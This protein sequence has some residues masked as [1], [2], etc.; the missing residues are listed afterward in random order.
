MA[1]HLHILGICGTFMGGL[2]QLAAA[3]GFR[4]T[5]SDANVYPP[6]STQLEA[7]GIALLEGYAPGH[8]DPA[9]DLVIIGNALSRGNPAVETVLARGLDYCS[10]P[11][12]L[13]R[14]VLRGRW[15]LGVAGT[16]GKTTTSSLLAWILE[17]AGLAPGFLIGGVPGNF[18]VSARE[19]GGQYFVVEADEYDTA[20]FDKRSKFVHYRPKTL[21]LGNLEYDHADIFP[22]LAA[23]Q[24]QFHHLLRCVPGNGRILRPRDCPALDEVEALGCWTPVERWSLAGP[25]E[26]PAAAD[27]EGRLQSRDGARLTL[28]GPAG[29]AG[30]VE[31]LLPGQHN[32]NNAIAA[33]AAA[34]HAGVTPERALAALA[35]FRGVKRRLELLG[36]VAGVSVYDDF[37]H[38][39]TAIAATLDA[40]RARGCSGRLLAL[41]EPRS[42]TMR[43]GRHREALAA[44]VA[45]AD[46]VYWYQPP[47]MDW[48]LEA[49][50]A[51]GTVP[52]S[53]SDDVERLVTAVV[54]E[55][56]KGDQIVIMSNGSFAGIHQRLLG[57]L[58]TAVGA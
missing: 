40:L 51:A 44:S 8:L 41:V 26:A 23:I 55:A 17:D 21:V 57:A 7:A 29:D 50:A 27:W 1:Q 24:R 2:A 11:E 13:A 37:A 6:M 28:H 47:G 46:R 34:V 10:G 19:G 36:E 20:F 32:A 30:T 45:A 48:S 56:Q 16:H 5:G 49:V 42:N 54:R 39:P 35:R 9:P 52:A 12:W 4:V 38:H 31:W 43:M 15:V 22:D 14:E 33:V 53:V 58:R 25:G 18:G 3:R